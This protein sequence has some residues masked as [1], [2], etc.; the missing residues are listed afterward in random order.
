MAPSRVHPTPG[1]RK[2]RT[3]EASV[4]AGIVLDPQHVRPIRPCSRHVLDGD[5]DLCEV[6]RRQETLQRTLLAMLVPDWRDVQ[7]IG[8]STKRT[9]SPKKR[10][11]RDSAAET[12]AALIPVP[13]A[14]SI[15]A[16][17]AP[18][19]IAPAA[20]ASQRTPAARPQ[21]PPRP[22]ASRSEPAAAPTPSAGSPAPSTPP[23]PVPAAGRSTAPPAAPTA[24][25]QPRPTPSTSAESDTYAAARLRFL[26]KT[27]PK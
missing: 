6:H 3:F 16:P 24:T 18:P 27:P 7:T 4:C 2:P 19:V 14:S 9:M 12:V 1:T 25:A 5:S 13:D 10:T 11:R 15:A 23:A 22:P 26:G 20:P 17:E 8:G 21:R